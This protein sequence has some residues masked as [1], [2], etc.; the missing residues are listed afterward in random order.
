VVGVR[1]RA[2]TVAHVAVCWQTWTSASHSIIIQHEYLYS[3]NVV[4]F[5]SQLLMPVS[6]MKLLK[7]T[8]K[9][10]LI[11]EFDVSEYHLE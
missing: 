8:I 11:H 9:L 5:F 7:I 2:P 6:D 4:S 1:P 3:L 10:L